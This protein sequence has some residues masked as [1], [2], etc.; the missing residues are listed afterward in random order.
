VK[1]KIIPEELRLRKMLSI[2]GK[3]YLH[4]V[5]DMAAKQLH[6]GLGMTEMEFVELCKL[7][8]EIPSHVECNVRNSLNHIDRG[9][10]VAPM[11]RR[12]AF[13]IAR[14]KSGNPETRTK[15]DKS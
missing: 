11:E 5:S 14:R 4:S 6:D 13:K 7:H 2:L 3:W 9:W 10:K 1:R 15:G 12:T 8:P